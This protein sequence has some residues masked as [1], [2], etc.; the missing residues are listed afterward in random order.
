[1]VV[2]VWLLGLQLHMESVP[3]ITTK[4][5]EFESCSGRKALDK[6]YVIKFVSD[7]RHISGFLRVLWFPSVLISDEYNKAFLVTDKR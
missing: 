7:L 5:C 1:M 4:S 2:I 3:I 6:H